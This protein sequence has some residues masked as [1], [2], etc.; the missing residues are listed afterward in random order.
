MMSPEVCSVPYDAHV[1]VNACASYY[2]PM[3][4]AFVMG[5]PS[6]MMRISM[7]S[8]FEARA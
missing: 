5:A 4:A 2:V 7:T 6:C 3:Y 8:G 1:S